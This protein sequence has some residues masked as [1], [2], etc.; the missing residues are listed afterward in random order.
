MAASDKPLTDAEYAE[1]QKN[2]AIAKA[3]YALDPKGTIAALKDALKD[4]R[5]FPTQSG[6]ATK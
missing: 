5:D 4:M 1:M 3:A 2:H 6:D